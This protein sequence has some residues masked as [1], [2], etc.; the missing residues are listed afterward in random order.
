[1]FGGISTGGLSEIPPAAALFGVGSAGLAALLVSRKRERRRREEQ[2]SKNDFASPLAVV[3]GFLAAQDERDLDLMCSFV[4]ENIVYINEPHDATRH[5]KGID[6]FRAAFEGSPCLWADDARLEVIREACAGDTVFFERL[7]QF[8]IDGKWLTI[9]VC[10]YM[11]VSKSKVVLWK[12]YW[13]YRKYK[14]KTQELFGEK[15]SMFKTKRD[16]SRGRKQR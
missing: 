15:F 14:T 7:D 8:L 13:C 3:R 5:I 10:G 6:A 1:M 4:A 11:V 12:D 16:E 2:S 9:P